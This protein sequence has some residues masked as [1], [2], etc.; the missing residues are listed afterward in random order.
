[1]TVDSGGQQQLL[2]VARDAIGH[3]LVHTEAQEVIVDDYPAAL[4]EIACTFVTLHIGAA[5]RGCIGSLRAHRPLAADVAGH[6]YGAAF[7]DGR[8]SPLQHAELPQLHI[9]ISILSPLYPL[10][11]EGDDGLLALLRPNSDG[12]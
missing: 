2:A 1:M 7:S 8:F 12:F 4:R 9:H 10:E 11:F 6:A 3:G 5:L